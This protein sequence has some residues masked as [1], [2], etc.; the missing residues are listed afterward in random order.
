MKKY[1]LLFFV[2]GI[3]VVIVALVSWFIYPVWWNVPLGLIGVFLLALVGVLQVVDWVMKISANF[4]LLTEQEKI[5]NE[6]PLIKTSPANIREVLGRGGQVSFINRRVQDKP[7]LDEWK[8]VIIVGKMKSGKTREAAELIQWAID[9]DL[10]HT[11]QIYEPS[12]TFRAL[13]A[14]GLEDSLKW[15]LDT[16]RKVLVFIDDFPKQLSETGKKKMGN[17]I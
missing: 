15:K 5:S 1:I 9:H 2:I 10:I 11:D 16:G 8:K 3:I 12:Q 7:I 14:S 6:P 13:D 4:K 17:S